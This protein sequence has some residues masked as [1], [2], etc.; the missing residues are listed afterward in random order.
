MYQPSNSSSYTAPVPD[1]LNKD[2]DTLPTNSTKSPAYNYS[3]IN[4][5]RYGMVNPL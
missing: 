1:P 5:F 2:I 3:Q 4:T